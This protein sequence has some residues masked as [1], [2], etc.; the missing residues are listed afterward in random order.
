MNFRLKVSAEPQDN[1][2]ET[3]SIKG[4]TALAVMV[5]LCAAIYTDQA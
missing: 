2:K 3:D 1:Y 4:K 5:G